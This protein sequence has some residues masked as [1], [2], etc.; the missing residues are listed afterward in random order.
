MGRGKA[1]TQW[2]GRAGSRGPWQCPKPPSC[3]AGTSS[4][5]GSRAAA[6][7]AT[8]L[9]PPHIPSPALSCPQICMRPASSIPPFSTFYSSLAHVDIMLYDL[10]S[11]SMTR[12]Q[13][14]GGV[15]IQ[16]VGRCTWNWT[17]LVCLQPFKMAISR[18]KFM[19]PTSASCRHFDCNHLHPSSQCF[20][21][22]QYS[23]RLVTLH[24]A[25]EQLPKTC[26]TS[27]AL[28]LLT[29]RHFDIIAV[30]C[31]WEPCNTAPALP[32]RTR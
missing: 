30:Y 10:S 16:G 27:P 29:H 13:G 22:L 28:S 3:P 15:L 25:K 5:R 18:T 24:S 11:H 1:L 32:V 26:S 17:M 14:Y 2:S 4:P 20:E 7:S 23:H 21:H 12:L 6:D 9:H 19:P 8:G 31:I